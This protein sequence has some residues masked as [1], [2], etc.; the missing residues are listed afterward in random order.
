MGYGFGVARAAATLLNDE[1][2][3]GAVPRVSEKQEQL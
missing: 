1:Q 3:T 2:L